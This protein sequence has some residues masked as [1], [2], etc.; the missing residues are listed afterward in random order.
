MLRWLEKPDGTRVLQEWIV[1]KVS[2]DLCRYVDIPVDKEPQKAREFTIEF[3]DKKP[4]GRI[5]KGFGGLLSF[6]GEKPDVMRLIH[7]REVL[8][9]NHKELDNQTCPACGEIAPPK[10]II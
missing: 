8:P 10:D 3:D 1:S 2:N 4:T 5:W 6:I 9:C 7:V